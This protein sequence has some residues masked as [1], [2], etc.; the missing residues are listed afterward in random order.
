MTET[1]QQRLTWNEFLDLHEQLK[2]LHPRHWAIE[3]DKLP[4]TIERDREGYPVYLKSSRSAIADAV[5][6]YARGQ[7][8]GRVFQD[9]SWEHYCYNPDGQM[10]EFESSKGYSVKQF[11]GAVQDNHPLEK[12]SGV[13]RW[14][15]LAECDGH[16]LYW[17]AN[18]GKYKDD[19]R[20]FPRSDLWAYFGYADWW[21]ERA[22][23]VCELAAGMPSTAMGRWL[24]RQHHFN[25]TKG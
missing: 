23:E 9:G 8:V 17:C 4:K 16:A 14:I 19:E 25:P 3:W 7:L 12:H 15:F 2:R 18:T 13:H 22:S 6:V 10:V 1:K 5:Q 24:W 11:W 21:G 20:E